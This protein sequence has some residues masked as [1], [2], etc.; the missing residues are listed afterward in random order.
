MV[1]RSAAW[2]AIPWLVLLGVASLLIAGIA[3]AVYSD[4][5]YQQQATREAQ[6][7]AAILAAS[8]TAALDFDD[9]ATIQEYVGALGANPQIEAAGVYDEAG[10]LVASYRRG[11]AELPARLTADGAHS[12]GSQ[13]SVVAPARSGRALVGHVLLRS[14]LEPLARRISRYS[15]IVLL[16]GMGALVVAA[17]GAAYAALRRVN[18]ELAASEARHRAYW[19]NT[20]ESLFSL[21]VSDDGALRFEGLNPAHERSTG[22]RTAEIAGKTPGEA[23]PA[24]VAPQL[25]ANYR[26]CI[27][28]GAPIAYPESLVL[29]AGPRHWETVLAPVRDASGRIARVIGSSRDV[30]ERLVAEESLRQSQKMEALGQLTGGVAHDFNNLLTP[31]IGALDIIRRRIDGDERA[32]RLVDGA[33]ASAERSRALVQRLLAFARRQTLQARPVDVAALV[34]GMSDLINRSLGPSIAVEVRLA[35]DLPPAIVDPNQLELA[36]LNLAVNARDAMPGGG[37][38]TIVARPDG[39]PPELPPGRYVMIAVEDS[40]TGMDAETL[41]RATE[42]FFSTKGVGKG[43]GLGLSAVH[44]L[45]LQSGGAFRL[46]S[47]IGE[48]TCAELWLPVAAGEAA[49]SSSPDAEMR[50]AEREA[51]ILVVDD[52]EA[53][54]AGTVEML[55]DLGYATCEA[56]SAAAALAAVRG[57]AAPDLV[58]TDHLMPGTTGAEFAGELAR[59]HPSLPVLLVSGYADLQGEQVHLPRLPKPF[60][61]ADLA[62]RVAELLEAASVRS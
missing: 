56:N 14:D 10:T 30:T 43:T 27:A 12:D 3:T 57:G 15:I 42:P 22:L 32:M 37:R 60:R 36:I 20:A 26:R 47:T 5:L 28:A 51:T 25:E 48:G 7:Q 46:T 6:A 19:D 16:A 24:E 11:S 17:V 45:A 34:D 35:P 39:T 21:Q 13:L 38:L 31:I 29:P 8:V 18:D 58:V 52:E 61:Q 54:R 4:R 41:R 33:L 59:S 62:N 23:L 49:E 2:A 1:P 44:G 50:R 53:V 55:R 40:G 9:A